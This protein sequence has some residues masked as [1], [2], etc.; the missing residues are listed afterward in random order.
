MT[1]NVSVITSAFV[2]SVADRRLSR[3]IGGVVS[4]RA[5]KM[6][7]LTCADASVVVSYNGI[8]RDTKGE[9]PND[10]LARMTDLPSLPLD[11]VV[12][13]IKADG[14]KRLDALE[15]HCDTRHS[16]TLAGFQKSRPCLILISNYE[17]LETDANRATA[18]TELRVG[19][20]DQPTMFF[21]TG[22]TPKRP[23]QLQRRI[24]DHWQQR[25]A[26]ERILKTLVK[27]VR[28]IAYNGQRT[29]SVGAN[30][31]SVILRPPAAFSSNSHILGRSTVLENPNYLSPGMLVADMMIDTAPG[32]DGPAWRFD[33]R[34]KKGRLPEQPCSKCGS[35]VPAGQRRC[36]VCDAGQV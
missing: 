8:G 28:D 12:A 10:W 17:S 31:Q 23:Q 20:I 3:P 16:F 24:R 34:A 6:T 26:P 4:D 27:A 33:P 22:V 29:G 2:V 7:C 25:D 32:P 36:G 1:V 14:D 18:D 9:T 13:R 30:L 11:E 35:P 19:R 5:N 21:L 15:R